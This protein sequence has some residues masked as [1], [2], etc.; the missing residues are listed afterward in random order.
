MEDP[1]SLGV[2]IEEAKNGNAQAFRAIYDL[3]ADRL[4]LHV[5]SRAQS[6][7]DALDVMQ[8]TFVAFWQSLGSFSYCSDG[9]TRAYLYRI[10]SRKLDK[11]YR[12]RKPSVQIDDIANII[13]ERDDDDAKREAALAVEAVRKL[14]GKDLEIAELRYFAG[15]KFDEIAELT[16]QNENTVKVRHHRMIQKLKGLLGYQENNGG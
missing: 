3:L 11:I 16:G 6:R 10:A 13:A 7:D 12:S 5:R 2:L 15:L 8:E 1:N 9:Q 14:H 4:F